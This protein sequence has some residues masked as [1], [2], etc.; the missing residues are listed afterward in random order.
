MVKVDAG[1]KGGAKG[2]GGQEEWRVRWPLTGHRERKMQGKGKR[3]GQGDSGSSRAGV[4]GITRVAE[5][6]SAG[7]AR[8]LWQARKPLQ[9]TQVGDGSRPG[10]DWL[11]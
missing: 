7:D 9:P 2:L 8:D 4:G 1:V 11:S 5:S 10:T 3:M 6:S